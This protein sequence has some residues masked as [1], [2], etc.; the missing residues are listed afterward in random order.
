VS[1]ITIDPRFCGPAESA[2]GGYACGLLASFVEGPAQVTLRLPPP[3]ARTLE[4][5]RGGEGGVRLLSGDSLVAEAFPAEVA[6]A[7]AR[8]VTPAQA[9]EAAARYEWAD[10]AVHP[11]PTCFVCGPAREAGDGMRVSPGPVPGGQGLYAAPW[12][13]DAS[14]LDEQG[15][16]RDEFV[17]AALDCPGGLVTNTFSPEGPVLLGRLAADLHEPVP[18]GSEYVLTSWAI[19]REGR[20]MTTGSA[21]FSAQGDLHAVARAVWIEVSG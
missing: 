20:K 6:A 17:W 4:V 19:D 13:P 3:L 21:L 15:H 1:E 18:G 10:P 12:R 9:R 5:R 2:N 16:V 11:Y 14:L 7:G 8:A